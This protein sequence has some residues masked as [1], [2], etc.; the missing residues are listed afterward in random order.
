MKKLCYGKHLP[1]FLSALLCFSSLLAHS[2]VSNYNTI[3]WRYSNPKQFG[4][5]ALD[6]DFLDDNN[7]IAVG[8]DAGIAKS[9]DGGR[10]WKYGPFTFQNAAGQWQKPTMSDVHYVSSSVVYAVGSVGCMAKS[11]DGGNTWSFVRTPLYANAR[12]INAVWFVNENTGYIGGAWNTPDSIPKVYFTNNGGATWDSLSAPAVNGKTRVGYINNPNL[13]PILFDVTGKAKEIYRIEFTSPTTGYITGSSSQDFPR[14]PSSNAAPACTPTGT[15]TSTGSHAAALVWKFSNGVLTDYSLSKERLGYSGINTNT[16]TCTTLYGNITPMTQQYRAMNIINDSLIVLMSFNNNIVVR[17]HTGVNDNVTNMATGLQEK[18]RYQIMSYPFPPT[19]GPQAGPPIPNPNNNL[20]SNPY[21][22]RRA[23]N[24]KLFAGANFGLLWTSTDTGRTWVREYSLPQGKNYSGFATWALD[25]S[26]SGKLLSMGQNGV[27]A[28]SSSAA[29]TWQSNYS[30]QAVGA[31]TKIDFADCN[32]GMATGGASIA[33]TF[34][35]GKNWRETVRTDFVALNISINSYAFINNNPAR[36]YFVTTT[37]TVY[38]SD[39]M[40]ATTPTLDPVFANGNEQINDVATRGN[41]SV[42]ACGLSGFSVP[43]A[44][45]SPKVFRSFNGGTTWTTIN[46]FPAGTTSQ[47]FTDI[48]FPT[49]LIG[50]VAGSR[51]T[52]WKTTNGGVS[53]SKLP[54]PTPGVTPQISYTDMFALDANTVYLTGNGFPRK[55]VFRTTDGGNT[56]QDITNNILTLGG[57]NLNG[58]IFH[59]INNG[60]VVGPGGVMYKTTN[61]G[62]SWELDIAPTSCLFSTMAFAPQSVPAGTPFA[63]RRL[64]IT[65][66]GLPNTAGHI[67]E[68]GNPANLDVSSSEVLTATCDNV[69]EGSVV[70]SATGG[71]APYTYSINGGAF[72]SS[73][74][75]SGLTPGVKTITIRDAACGTL[76][77]TVTVDVKPSPVVNAGPDKTIVEGYDVMLE[78]NSSIT[79]PVSIAWTPNSTLTGANTYT[80]IAKPLTTTNYTMTV[81]SPNGCVSTDNALVTV[82]PY[83]LKVMDAFTPNGD[84]MNDRWIVT[85]NGGN[86]TKQVIAAVYNRYGNQVYKNDNYTNNWDGTY[87][88]KPVADGTYYYVIRYILLNG[89][90]ITLQGDVTIL[91]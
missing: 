11:I 73:G 66:P 20:F 33:Q 62:A 61:A 65:G 83:C 1:Y 56:W 15:T 75:F 6:V 69:A 10:N 30:M 24:G 77:K 64:F 47:S 55:V 2:Q 50:Y 88:G 71:I 40:T 41:D 51:D 59:D 53:W 38:K 25:I 18:G 60:Y 63:N 3:N 39:N 90:V 81:V 79:S 13:A 58:V 91:R 85:N 49:S 52:I 7:V 9:T 21:Q 35:G 14:I 17:V 29:P 76:T 67:L 57:G 5:T 28:D 82:I 16:I 43:A 46:T 23:A 12:N 74:T 44:S 86:C 22:I 45:R 70:V 72:Q 84:G 27:V 80:P 87:N 4:F 42:W 54:L 36:A 89:A 32:N 8:S 34:D 37:G 48:E 68:Y 31:Y 26:P 19:Q 78:G